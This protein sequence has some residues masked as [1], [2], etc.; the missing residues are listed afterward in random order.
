[1]AADDPGDW[2]GELDNEQVGELR[3]VPLGEEVATLAQRQPRS[4]DN[5]ILVWG[6]AYAR[7]SHENRGIGD[8][9]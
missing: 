6:T 1:V 5:R 2:V 4:L 3:A 7:P 9:I 8:R